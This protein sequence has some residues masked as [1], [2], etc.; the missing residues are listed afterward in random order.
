MSKDHVE[1]GQCKGHVHM[2][3]VSEFGDNSLRNTVN[4]IKYK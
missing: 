3:V 1:S 4:L 2:V